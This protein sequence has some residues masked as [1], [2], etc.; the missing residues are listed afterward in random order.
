MTTVRV[1][2]AEHDLETHPRAALLWALRDEV[3]C[4]SVKYGCGAGQCGACRVLVDGTPESSCLI[5][6]AEAVGRDVRTLEGYVADGTAGPVVDALLAIDAG[7]C[8][9]CLPGIVTTL[10]GLQQ[11]AAPGL[12]RDELLRALDEHLCRCGSHTRILA[13]AWAALGV[14]DG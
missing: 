11:R 14:D 8:G 7:Q 1:N 2:G 9:Y 5:T 6:I 13:A 12:T 4:S 10:V 3:G